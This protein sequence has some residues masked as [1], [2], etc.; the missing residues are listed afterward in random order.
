MFESKLNPKALDGRYSRVDGNENTPNDG[1]WLAE[2]FSIEGADFVETTR[3]ELRLT[4]PVASL[5]VMPIGTP[6]IMV[7]LTSFCDGVPDNVKVLLSK[8]SQSGPLVSEQVIGRLE[9][10][11]DRGRVYENGS[12]TRAT[13]GIWELRGKPIV[14][15]ASL[16]VLKIVTVIRTPHF[17]ILNQARAAGSKFVRKYDGSFSLKVNSTRMMNM[18]CSE[19]AETEI[20]GRS[21]T[22]RKCTMSYFWVLGGGRRGTPYRCVSPCSRNLQ[23]DFA[24]QGKSGGRPAGAWH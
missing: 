16:R 21:Q 2:D 7:E 11:V 12:D 23:V 1:N 17:S 14:G 19:R 3:V 24:L 15:I 5:A 22:E 20:D 10:K 6:V 18:P 4:D 9:T 8:E 13:G